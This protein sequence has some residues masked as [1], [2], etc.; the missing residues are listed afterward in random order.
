MKSNQQGFT[1]I[2]L[3][4]VVAIIGILAAVALPAYQDYTARAKMSEVVLAATTC[5]NTISEAAD[6]GLPATPT[7]NGWGCGE[8]VAAGGTGTPIE[9]KYVKELT[10][11]AAG[12]I[13][14]E[15]QNIKASDPD[16]QKVTLTP[17]KTVAAAAA[18]AMAAADYVQGSNVAIKTWK[19]S[20]SGDKKYVPAS[21]RQ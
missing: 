10:T 20:Y 2:E 15:A 19:C 18:D 12:A 4:I 21:C 8:A 7:A 6:S 9:S 17:Y 11:T 1:L 16:G 3:M 14:V 13:S 5:K